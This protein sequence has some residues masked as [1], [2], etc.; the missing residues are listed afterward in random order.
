VSLYSHSVVDMRLSDLVCVDDGGSIGW[1]TEGERGT[2]MAGRNSRS[3]GGTT[4]IAPGSVGDKNRRVY[5]PVITDI[6]STRVYVNDAEVVTK[7][8]TKQVTS[9]CAFVVLGVDASFPAASLEVRIGALSCSRWMGCAKNKLWWMTPSWG[10]QAGE[11]PLETQFLLAEL[12]TGGY[13][14]CVLPLIYDSTFSGILRGER[15]ADCCF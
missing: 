14:A 10:V 13:Y 1:E 11:V 6:D 4:G 15:Y 9:A 12:K 7:Q 5:I 2:P 8:V 3:E